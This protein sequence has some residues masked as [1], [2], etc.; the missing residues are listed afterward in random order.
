MKECMKCFFCLSTPFL[1]GTL[2][3]K[4]LQQIFR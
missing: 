4:G 3:L 2:Q 1:Q